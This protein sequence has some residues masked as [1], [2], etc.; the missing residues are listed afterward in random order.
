MDA[1]KVERYL[2]A[3]PDRLVCAAMLR[4]VLRMPE[5]T[6]R[7]QL[8]ALARFG[9]VTCDTSARPHLYRWKENSRPNVGAAE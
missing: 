4:T 6:A 1:Y 9:L 5:T 7:H 8:R 2:R 3:H